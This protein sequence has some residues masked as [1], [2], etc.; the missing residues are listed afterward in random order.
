M[1]AIEKPRVIAR[2]RVHQPR[3]RPCLTRRQQ[4]MYVV[5]HQH[6]GMQPAT[7]PPQRLPQALQIAL[8]VKIVQKARQAVVAPLHHVLRNAGKIEARLASHAPQH[9]SP[10]LRQ[11]SAPDASSRHPN[12]IPASGIVPDTFSHDALRYMTPHVMVTS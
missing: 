3:Q 4:Q 5:A 1:P 2:E 7:E 9:Q 8:T 10:Y 12:L 6:V 11:P